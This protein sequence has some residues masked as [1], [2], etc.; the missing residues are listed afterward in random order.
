M[1]DF[2]AWFLVAIA[3]YAV[4]FS[5]VVIVGA[6]MKDAPYRQFKARLKREYLNDDDPSHNLKSW[7]HHE[8]N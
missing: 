1:I 4:L 3:F 2:L 8:K 6:Y 7:N 5:I